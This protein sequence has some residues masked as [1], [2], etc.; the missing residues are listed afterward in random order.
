[1]KLSFRLK[2]EVVDD[3]CDLLRILLI[4]AQ[5]MLLVPLS[6]YAAWVSNGTHDELVTMYAVAIH[7]GVSFTWS[8]CLAMLGL[9]GYEW[10]SRKSLES[11]EK[12]RMWHYFVKRVEKFDRKVLFSHPWLRAIFVLHVHLLA[13]AVW[14]HP[15]TTTLIIVYGCVPLVVLSTWGIIMC[16]FDVTAKD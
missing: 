3:L 8:W 14:V 10:G 1:M 15:T 16:F 5:S 13:L 6:A 4:C 9:I 2:Q 12:T 7:F 11:Q